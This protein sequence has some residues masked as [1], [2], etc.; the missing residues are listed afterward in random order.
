MNHDQNDTDH[1]QSTDPSNRAQEQQRPSSARPRT[2]DYS[3]QTNQDQ[4]QRSRTTR[5][6]AAH[7][8]ITIRGSGPASGRRLAMPAAITCQEATLSILKR[9]SE[10]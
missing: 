1:H 3:N 8:G 9:S 6:R 2:D 5:S 7:L 4:R 10:C